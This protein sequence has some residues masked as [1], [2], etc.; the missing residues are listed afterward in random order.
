MAAALPLIA[1]WILLRPDLLVLQKDT[2]T[3]CVQDGKT[4][5]EK[6]KSIA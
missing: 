3:S 1:A 2:H 5:N 4:K 6:T